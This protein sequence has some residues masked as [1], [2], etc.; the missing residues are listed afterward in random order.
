VAVLTIQCVFHTFA[1]KIKKENRCKVCTGC[2]LGRWRWPTY[3]V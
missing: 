3:F 2:C 1:E